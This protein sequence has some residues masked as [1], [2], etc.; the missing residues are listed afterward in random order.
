MYRRQ[1]E[2]TALPEAPSSPPA[3]PC[4]KARCSEGVK[5]AQ[6]RVSQLNLSW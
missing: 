4:V 5:N 6:G 1:P 3:L 2:E